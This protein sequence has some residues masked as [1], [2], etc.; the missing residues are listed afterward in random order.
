MA[1]SNVKNIVTRA[2]R[3]FCF[4]PANLNKELTMK[5]KFLILAPHT[6]TTSGCEAI[7]ATNPLSSFRERKIILKPDLDCLT[8]EAEV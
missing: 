7:H 1:K 8:G 4:S 2:R 3:T 5:K 6:V